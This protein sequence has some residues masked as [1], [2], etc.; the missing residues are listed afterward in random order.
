MEQYITCLRSNLRK[1]LEEEVSSGRL[2]INTAKN[3]ALTIHQNITHS[4]GDTKA[5]DNISSSLVNQFPD[6]KHAFIK[7]KLICQLDNNKRVVDDEVI[8]LVES[9]KLDEALAL[10]TKLKK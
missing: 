3:Y 9:D 7:A 4:I 8:K 5:L 2:D 10:L 6:L 1:Y